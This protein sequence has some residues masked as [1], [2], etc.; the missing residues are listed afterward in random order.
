LRLDHQRP[1]QAVALYF[2]STT[3]TATSLSPAPGSSG[4]DVNLKTSKRSTRWSWALLLLLIPL[5]AVRPGSS[6]TQYERTRQLFLHGY[7]EKC[8]LQAHREYRKSIHFDRVLADKFLLLEAES[9]EWRGLHADAL[10]A[11]KAW[12][13]SSPDS[14]ETVRERVLEG[15]AL[16]HLQQFTE[17]TDRFAEA[18]SLCAKHDYASCGDL[19]R[20][21]GSMS[22]S[23]GNLAQAR[24]ELLSSLT[25]ARKYK[26]R[27]NEANTLINLGVVCLQSDRFDEA[28]DWFNAA[29]R[30]ATELGAQDVAQSAVG[31]VGWANFKLGDSDKALTLF[32]EAQKDSIRLGDS[33]SEIGWLATTAYVHQSTGDFARALKSDL[34]YL[35]RAREIGSKEDILNAL[36]DLAHVSV[37][38][39]DF[40]AASNYIE[41]ASPLI[42]SNDN[43]LDRLYMLLAQGAVA[44][45]QQKSSQAEAIFRTVERDPAAETSMKL[46]AKRELAHLYEQRGDL[47]SADGMYR[48]ALLTFESA[49][50][51]LRTETSKLPFSANATAIY[52]DYIQFLISQHRSD[53]ALRVA[54][55]S[56]ARTLAQGL[57]LL[58]NNSAADVPKLRPGDIARKTGATLLFY[59]LSSRQSYLWTITPK[60]TSLYTLPPQQ[61][62]RESVA[63]YRKT[64]LGFGDPLENPDSDGRALY[65]DLIVPASASVGPNSNIVLLTDGAL[66]QLNFET[67]IV[68]SPHPHYWIEDA[69]ITSAPS[70]QMLASAHTPVAAQRKLLLIGDAIPPSPDYPN[71][72]MASS[73]M[74]QIQQQIGPRSAVLY[75]REHATPAAYLESDPQQFAYIHFV[76]HGVASGTDPLDSAIILSRSSAVEDSFKLHARDII[77]HPIRANLVTISACYGSGTRIYA[78]EGPIGLAWAFL[79]AGAHNVIGALWEVSDQSAPQMMSNLYQGIERG[80]SPSAALRQAKLAMLHSQSSFRKPFYWAPLQVY[81]GL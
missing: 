20:A 57:R 64:L 13:H 69:N 31:N 34:Q 11:L 1:Y 44:A 32:D 46:D 17:A 35:R 74:R 7:L 72:P 71:L 9:M 62:I 60:K 28:L 67:L 49:R 33:G 37:A 50:D 30:I 5:Q 47:A 25:H 27:F 73:E 38:T 14:E 68:P 54:D 21:R 36:E 2:A 56:R 65:Q 45:G 77:Q 41:Q 18:A 8:Q 78:G 39:G 24:A 55:Q 80:L 63:H 59:W 70:L 10:T 52:D 15:A 23:R 76:A 75:S 40:I 3:E 26:D 51:Q 53:E 48:A 4:L 12:T 81:T 6:R 29:Y 79:R 19:L 22:I 42:Q 61:Q 43:R 66:S 58:S 16:D